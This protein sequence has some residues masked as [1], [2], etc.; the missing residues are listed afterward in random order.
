MNDSKFTPVL[1]AVGQ[2]T[3]K[4]YHSPPIE[5]IAQACQSAAQDSGRADLL[6]TIQDIAM[7]GLTVD[8]PQ[9][10]TPISRGFKNPPKSLAIQLGME[11]KRLFYSGPGG[12]TPQYMVNLFASEIARGKTD[13][14]LLAGGESLATMLK[15]FDR[16]YKWLFS[17]SDWKDNP[18]GEPELLG[19][20]RDANTRY[21][22]NHGLDLPS[23]VYPLFENAL[24][25]HYGHS[26]KDHQRKI[27]ELFSRLT[28]VAANNPLAWFQQA[29]TADELATAGEDN[30]MVSFP[31]TKRLNSMIM[32][33][34]AAAVVMMSTEKAA[35]L[36]IPQDQWVYLH[37][38]A[39]AN[40]I[41]N[42]SE[43]ANFHSSPAIRHCGQQALAMAD[44]SINE[45]KHFD[46]YSCFPSAVQIAC[47]ELGITPS[48][49]VELSLTGG[50][51]YFGGPGNTY[52]LHGIAHMAD[53]LRANPGEFGLV[54]AN[55]WYLTK[56]SLG[57]YSTSPVVNKSYEMSPIEEMASEQKV[58]TTENPSGKGVI[59]TYTV[60]FDKSGAP[61]KG[62][63]IGRDEN[64]QR[65]LANTGSDTSML[66]EICEK[67]GA[68]GRSGTIARKGKLNLFTLD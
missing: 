14:V 65:F 50:L 7:T 44:I 16:W 39:D 19:S 32:V 42:V 56:H 58:K 9:A 51:P 6:S 26:I 37:G 57:I 48:S 3:D 31:Y 22:E 15:K 27:G 63:I 10:K 53:R 41:W 67:D 54:N 52:S 47:D 18:G 20:Y 62:I 8:A 66:N 35:K 46:I 29:R 2:V 61:S 45:V 59:E 60:S 30:R 28:Q 64:G 11:P 1:V 49:N 5:I 40:D 21:E 13:S 68:I 43:R 36:G 38:H 34:Q 23:V 33:N 17:T 12:N 24:R 25:A 4:D 55:G